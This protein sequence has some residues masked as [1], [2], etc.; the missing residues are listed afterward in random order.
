MS[1]S[2]TKGKKIKKNTKHLMLKT[3]ETASQKQIA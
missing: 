1:V 2:F 3:V